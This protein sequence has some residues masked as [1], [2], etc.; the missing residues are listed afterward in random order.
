[1]NSKMSQEMALGSDFTLKKKW[2]EVA[3]MSTHEG[4]NKGVRKRPCGIYVAEICNPWKKTH[5]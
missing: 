4:H 1:M 2:G 3:G 5:D